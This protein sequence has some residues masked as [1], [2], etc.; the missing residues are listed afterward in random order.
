MARRHKP[1]KYFFPYNIAFGL[2]ITKV[3]LAVN[4]NSTLRILT[5]YRT[6]TIRSGGEACVNYVRYA[7]GFFDIQ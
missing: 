5:S 3:D 7:C 6:N 4:L 1:F 2:S